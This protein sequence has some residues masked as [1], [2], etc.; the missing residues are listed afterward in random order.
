MPLTPDRRTFAAYSLAYDVQAGYIDSQ[1]IQIVRNF[2]CFEVAA[3]MQWDHNDDDSGYKQSFLVSIYL[4]G[5]TGPLQEGQ[6]S[7]LSQADSMMRDP[8]SSRNSK[9][10]G[11]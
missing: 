11:N 4:T 2:H 7:V 9:F 3:G 8:G 1:A 6:N 5:L 10:W